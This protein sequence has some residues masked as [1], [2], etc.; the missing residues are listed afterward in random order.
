ML[1][2]S[3]F[4]WP[5]GVCI[6]TISTIIGIGTA[7]LFVCVW[8]QEK[9]PTFFECT[10]HATCVHLHSSA[11]VCVQNIKCPDA[12]RHKWIS[13]SGCVFCSRT[14]RMYYMCMISADT[15]PGVYIGPCIHLV[16]NPLPLMRRYRNQ[17]SDEERS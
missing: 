4:F 11:F 1:F 5:S 3:E 6:R 2:H 10:F 9:R 13:A 7:G 12:F 8:G 14:F 16:F 17:S 15:K